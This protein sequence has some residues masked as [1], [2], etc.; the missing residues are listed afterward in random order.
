M[1]VCSIDYACVL[2]GMVGG[3]K[4]WILN[5]RVREIIIIAWQGE[6]RQV[7][8]YYDDFYYDELCGP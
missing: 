3:E 4:E 1:C 6:A 5:V 2:K 7:D 8:F